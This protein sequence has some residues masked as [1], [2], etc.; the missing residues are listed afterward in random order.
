MYLEKTLISFDLNESCKTKLYRPETYKDLF[1]ICSESDQVIA[2]GGGLSYS[3]AGTAPKATINM[4]MF[5]RILS[6]KETS[7]GATISVEAGITLES[8]LKFSIAKGYFLSILPGYPLITVGGC[9]AFNVHG[10]CQYNIGNF[11]SV[12]ESITLFHPLYGTKTLSR[13]ENSELFELTVGGI[14]LTG[15][16]LSVELKL[17]KLKGNKLKLN[18]AFVKN[19]LDAVEKME[20]LKGKFDYIY[21]WNDFNLNGA[22]FGQGY[23]YSEEFINGPITTQSP[24]N[25]ELKEINRKF[26]KVLN[27]LSIPIMTK[28]YAQMEK[29]KSTNELDLINGLFPI[30]GKEIYYKMFGKNGFYEYQFIVSPENFSNVLKQIYE[31]KS[32]LNIKIALAS[33]KLFS[34]KQTNLNFNGTGICLALDVAAGVNQKR[35]FEEIDQLMIRYNGTVNLSKDSRLTKETVEKLFKNY[36]EFKRK[37]LQ[38]DPNLKFQSTLSKRIGIT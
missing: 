22:K 18:K 28:V 38:Y 17:K 26:P 6:F 24:L 20:S 34:G 23:V 4:K 37:I 13:S 35:F 2:L 27:Q 29:L 30:L 5:D 21:S 15:I 8:L 10:K 9:V 7:E 32:R 36:G 31:L 16:I 33:L 11:E 25:L 12:V 19:P 1:K 3:L 14:G